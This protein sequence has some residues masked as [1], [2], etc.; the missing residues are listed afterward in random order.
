MSQ[1]EMVGLVML[2]VMMVVIVAM[3]GPAALGA[4]AGAGIAIGATRLTKP[5][6]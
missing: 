6:R 4:V 2:A 1:V 3:L 5:R